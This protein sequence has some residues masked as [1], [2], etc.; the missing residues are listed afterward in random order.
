MDPDREHYKIFIKL[1]RITYKLHT[2]YIQITYKL[3][4]NYI[5]IAYKLHKI[6]LKIKIFNENWKYKQIKQKNALSQL[7]E[8]NMK[9]TWKIS[10]NLYENI[11]SSKM[12][13]K[14]KNF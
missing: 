4:T 13:E 5:Q 14:K 10:W 12:F 2:N 6:T 8:N 11:K 3:H 9:V 1:H 7:H